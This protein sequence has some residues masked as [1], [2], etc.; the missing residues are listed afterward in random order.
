MKSFCVATETPETVE[1]GATIILCIDLN[2]IVEVVEAAV[3]L[4]RSANYD[5]AEHH[6]P[7]SFIING[8]RSQITNFFLH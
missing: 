1:S 8:I 4:P 3:S 6:S 7:F 5:F 2:N